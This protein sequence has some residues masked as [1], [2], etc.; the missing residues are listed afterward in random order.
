[1]G[2][3]EF[4]SITPMNYNEVIGKSK[5]WNFK[6]PI[7]AGHE[8]FSNED[9]TENE[10][11]IRQVNCSK[12]LDRLLRE[13]ITSISSTKAAVPD[14]SISPF[15]FE[16]DFYGQQHYWFKIALPLKIITLL[17]IIMYVPYRICIAVLS[18]FSPFNKLNTVL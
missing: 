14:T 10:I 3:G 7:I 15:D 17:Y 8:L 13:R 5:E 18:I 2:E 6:A 16:T 12:I 4:I 11:V 1:M 9:L